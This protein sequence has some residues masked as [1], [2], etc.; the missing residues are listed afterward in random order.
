MSQ[1][2]LIQVIL[3]TLQT[4]DVNGDGS[5]DIV[6]TGNNGGMMVWEAKKISD[7]Y[8]PN[9]KWT[10]VNFGFCVHAQK[11]VIIC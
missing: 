4:A 2:N 7:V 3:F 1:L 6:C 9:S 5:D 11:Q 10:D 8:D